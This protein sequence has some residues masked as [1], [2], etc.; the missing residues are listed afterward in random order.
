M[1]KKKLIKK[2]EKKIVKNKKLD[3]DLLNQEIQREI[4]L[5]IL[6]KIENLDIQNELI[7]EIT[8]IINSFN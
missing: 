8:N 2:L 6:K 1:K 5:I 7:K 4:S 3:K